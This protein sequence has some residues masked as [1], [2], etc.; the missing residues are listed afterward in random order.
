MSSLYKKLQYLVDFKVEYY[1]FYKD[2]QLLV[3]SIYQ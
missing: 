3:V 2:L 1:E